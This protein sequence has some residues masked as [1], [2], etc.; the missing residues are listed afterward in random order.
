MRKKEVP[1]EEGI[2]DGCRE[3]RYA[4]DDDGRYALAPSSGWEPTVAANRQAWDLIARQVEAV[5]Q[6]VLDDELSPLAFHMERSQ[7]DASLM[8]KYVGLAA[9]RVRRHLKPTVFRRLKPALIERY[10]TVLGIEPCELHAVPE[11][12]QEVVEKITPSKG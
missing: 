10:A 1:Q 7:M 6:Q 11:R 2:L 9:W 5:R 12:P 4:V 8:A 3:I